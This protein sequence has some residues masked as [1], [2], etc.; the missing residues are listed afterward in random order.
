MAL[1]N[2]SLGTGAALALAGGVGA[3]FLGAA[4]YMGIRASDR[5]HELDIV[6]VLTAPNTVAVDGKGH[7]VR[8]AA[9]T[10]DAGFEFQGR[11]SSIGMPDSSYPDGG[12][13]VAGAAGDISGA[14]QLWPRCSTATRRQSRSNAYG[15][16][17]LSM[18]HR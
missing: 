12:T 4:Y 3:V 11:R 9:T 6:E 14:S 17:N 5:K 7:V 15:T 8:S 10:T 1:L 2:K 13:L 16:H 18:P